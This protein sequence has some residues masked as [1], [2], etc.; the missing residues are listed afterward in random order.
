MKEFEKVNYIF[1]ELLNLSLKDCK[2]IIILIEK[3]IGITINDSKNLKSSTDS[4]TED[5]KV[6]SDE[7]A[8]FHIFLEEIPD[9]SKKMKTVVLVREITKTELKVAKNLVEGAPT[10]IKNGLNKQEAE[11]LKKRFDNIGVKVEIKL[12]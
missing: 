1:T 9:A 6:I 11:D 2:E 12:D 3:C 4:D 5:K 10:I 8:R 7:K